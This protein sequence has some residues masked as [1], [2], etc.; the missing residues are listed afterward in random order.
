LNQ[1]PV[2]ASGE[3]LPLQLLLD[4]IENGA[5]EDPPLLESDVRHG[6]AQG[7]FVEIPISDEFDLRNGRTLLDLEDQHIAVTLDP[8]V[9]EESGLVEGADDGP[10]HVIANRIPDLDR[11]IGEHGAG[12][13]PLKSLD[14]DVRYL[15]LL[16]VGLESPQNEDEAEEKTLMPAARKDRW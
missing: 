14:A 9:F 3:I 11:Q 16:R 15:E 5:V 10:R 1:D 4:P 12:G 8:N 6:L 2:F 13:D 7:L